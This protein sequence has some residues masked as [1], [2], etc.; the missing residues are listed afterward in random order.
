[1]V[2]PSSGAT[3]TLSGTQTSAAYWAS[4]IALTP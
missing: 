1:V 3:I 2:N 4:V